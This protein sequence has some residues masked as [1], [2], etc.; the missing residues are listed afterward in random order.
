MDNPWADPWPDSGESDLTTPSWSTGIGVRW[1]EPEGAG[2]LWNDGHHDPA[3]SET[4]TVPVT[5]PSPS[6]SPTRPTSPGEFDTFESADA[7]A[8][9]PQDSL[10]WDPQPW[11]PPEDAEEQ[12]QVDEWEMAKLQKQKQ[13]QHVVSLYLLLYMCPC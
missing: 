7:N 2:E 1:E 13:D 6:P 9:F 3:D 10:A 4:E 8:S 5:P 11:A 12:P